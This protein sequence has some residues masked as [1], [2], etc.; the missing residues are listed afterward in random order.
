M[1][2]RGAY[3][4]AMFVDI[5]EAARMLGL[6]PSTLRLQAKKGKLNAVKVSA[7]WFIRVEEVERY[8]RENKRG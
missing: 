1:S 7:F 4:S 6:A 8:R 5:P 2:T 3:G